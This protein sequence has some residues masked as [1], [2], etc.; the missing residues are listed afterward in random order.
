MRTPL[1]AVLV[2]CTNEKKFLKGVV[3]SL[4]KQT[5]NN[6]RIYILDNN[7]EDGSKEIISNLLPR[8]RS[9]FG[10]KYQTSNLTSIYFKSNL[11][12]AKANNIGLRRA[13]GDGADLCLVLNCDTVLKKDCVEELVESYLEKKK[14]EI[15]VGLIQPVILLA[16]DRKKINSVGNAI[17]YLGFGYCQDYLKSYKKQSV[18]KEIY[19]VSGAA[20]LMT[21]EYFRQVSGFD[22]EFFM[23]GEDQD[24][25][26]RG[27]LYGYRH[28][29]SQ[30]A[31]I[32]HYYQFG[33]H[34]LNKY[35]EEKN[36]LMML[37]KNYSVKSLILLSPMLVVNELALILYSLFEGWFFLKIKTYWAILVNSKTILKNRK[38]IQAKRVVN[39]KI[40]FSRFKAVIHFNPINNFIIQNLA[41]PVYWFYYHLVYIFI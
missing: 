36:R 16:N 21:R 41:N 3:D 6:L 26:W 23:T 18:D 24:I 19:S 27:L 1:V 7:S 9:S 38:I 28:F 34:K 8:G 25:S 5:Y 17:H 22:E 29:L 13:F 30:G 35:R 4:L 2:L 39:D 20:M 31:Q 15:K 37:L 11:G 32:Y 10:R 14:E 40:L 12:Y 33:R